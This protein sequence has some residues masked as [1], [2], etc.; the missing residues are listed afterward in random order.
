MSRQNA[1]A[2]WWI[3]GTI[4]GIKV[5]QPKNW[6]SKWGARGNNREITVKWIIDRGKEKMYGTGW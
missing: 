5:S 4:V 6:G 2:L 3:R 1:N